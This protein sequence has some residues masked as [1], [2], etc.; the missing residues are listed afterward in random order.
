MPLFDT[1]ISISN[2]K[3]K[4]IVYEPERRYGGSLGGKTYGARSETRFVMRDPYFPAIDISVLRRLAVAEKS[5]RIFTA[6]FLCSS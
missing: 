4:S 6:Y 3:I 1:R 2:A 5:E